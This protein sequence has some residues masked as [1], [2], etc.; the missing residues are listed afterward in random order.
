[1]KL[2]KLVF[3]SSMIL[4]TLITASS[5]SW[6]SMW[7]GLE[8]NLLSIIPLFSD[9]K[10]MLSSEAALKYFITQAMASLVLLM[11]VIMLLLTEEFI[12]PQMNFAFMM[13]MNTAL[14]TKVGAAPFHFW[15]PEV[16]EGLSWMNALILLTWQKIAPMMMIMVNKINTQFLISIIFTCLVASTLSGFNQI[17]LRKILAFSSINHIAWML[18]TMMISLSTWTVYF[19]VYSLINANIVILFLMTKSFYLNQI[20]NMLNQNKMVKLSFMINFLSLGGLPPFIGFMPKWL[21]INWMTNQGMILITV[22]L[23]V[24][25]LVML[26]IYMRVL[27]SSMVLSTEEPK[28]SINVS[29]S[30]LS[31]TNFLSISSL[32]FCTL[33]P[34][35]Y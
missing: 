6:F 8:I 4:G 12:H 33:I 26:Y 18:A 34:S 23:I 13:M 3:V 7:M 14:L 11:A 24:T 19:L 17:S 22:T 16:I 25:T 27:M 15:F 32:A 29:S 5:Y 28:I 30:T 9:S 35:F 1:M 2:H 10:N 21:V 31:M 20:S